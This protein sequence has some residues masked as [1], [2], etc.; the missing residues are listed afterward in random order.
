MREAPARLC[1]VA[2]HLVA[3]ELVRLFLTSLTHVELTR[4]YH[5]G[6]RANR[7]GF[8]VKTCYRDKHVLPRGES[9]PPTKG[10]RLGLRSRC[11][12][13][14]GETSSRSDLGQYALVPAVIRRN[15]AAKALIEAGK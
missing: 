7:E 8:M 1:L 14:I 15:L 5:A 2:Q 10:R 9:F 4:K 3:T 11:A 6:V 13:S 12:P